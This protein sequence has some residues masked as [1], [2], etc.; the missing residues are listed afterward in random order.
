MV[1][2]ARRRKESDD[3]DVTASTF[4]IHSI[5][6]YALIDIGSTYSYIASV[7]SA[8]LGLTIENTTREFSMIRMDWVV[9]YRVSLDCATKRV[10]LRSTEN[11]EVIMIVGD[12]CTVKEFPNVFLEELPR[13]PLDIEVEFGIDLLL[14]TTPVSIASNRMALKE[15][16]ELKA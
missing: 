8:N 6:Y 13:V 7:V 15:L 5:P 1:Y 4:F 2:A 14:G 3:S 9:E 11:N 10:T 16:T 12:I